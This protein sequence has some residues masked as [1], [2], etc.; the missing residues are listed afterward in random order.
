MWSWPVGL[1]AI[2]TR[3]VG[4]GMSERVAASDGSGLP[5]ELACPYDP[6]MKLLSAGPEAA[7]ARSP[8]LASDG[9]R[10]SAVR[11]AMEEAR[12]G[13]AR[14]DVDERCGPQDEGGPTAGAARPGP[15]RMRARPAAW[16]GRPSATSRRN[17][18]LAACVE[19]PRWR[20][21]WAALT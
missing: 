16:R 2:R 5:A 20:A 12:V 1:G 18:S 8:G 9:G 13:V 21:I 10:R 7:P 15:V 3:I 19:T 6:S 11:D 14:Q 4:S 17:I